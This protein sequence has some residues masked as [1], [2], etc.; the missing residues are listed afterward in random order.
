[1][2]TSSKSKPPVELLV[3]LKT[4]VTVGPHSP[5]VVVNHVSKYNLAFCGDTIF[6][7]QHID[8]IVLNRLIMHDVPRRTP[9]STHWE[10]MHAYF[11]PI[12]ERKTEGLE[13]CR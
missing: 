5:R 7:L 11:S 9:S 8:K 4:F 10:Q 2:K 3:Q 13:A 6:Y 1:M 12:C